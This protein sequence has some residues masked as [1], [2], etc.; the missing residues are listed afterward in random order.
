MS[1]DLLQCTYTSR[2]TGSGAERAA[3]LRD[4]QEVAA[5]NNPKL[6][7]TGS[8][9]VHGDRVVQVLE[10]H[11]S[12]VRELL[13]KIATDPRHEEFEVLAEQAIAV[14]AFGDWSMAVR[15]LDADCPSAADLRALIAGY[16]RSFQFD[17]AD[18]SALVRRYLLHAKGRRA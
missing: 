5:R 10:G 18:W 14:G 6:G 1:E 17:A 9:I 2:L 16:E 8:L 4:I 13:A 12:A 7:V 15:M 3:I 11:R